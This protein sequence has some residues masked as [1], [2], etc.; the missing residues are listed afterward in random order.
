[1]LKSHIYQP[2]KGHRALTAVAVAACG[3]QSLIKLKDNDGL[4]IAGGQ[5]KLLYVNC[6]FLWASEV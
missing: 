6:N 3:Q 5:V 4:G 2:P 1:M